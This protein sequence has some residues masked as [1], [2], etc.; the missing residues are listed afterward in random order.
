MSRPLWWATKS[1]PISIPIS[2][3]DSCA[4]TRFIRN[5]FRSFPDARR[6]GAQCRAAQFSKFLFPKSRRARH[7]HLVLSGDLLHHRQ[8]GARADRGV[9]LALSSVAGNPH[10]HSHVAFAKGKTAPAKKPSLFG[11]FS[12]PERNHPRDRERGFRP[13][14]RR[15]L[16]L[17]GLP[18]IFPFVLQRRGPRPGHDLFKRAA[19][20][21]LLL[22]AHF[23][24]RAKRDYL[25]DMELP[26]FLR[27][28]ID[29]AVSDQP[30]AAR[31][32]VLAALPKPP[33]V[34]PSQ[35]GRRRDD[36]CSR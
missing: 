8:L 21:L 29:P 18:A 28:Q 14:E 30:S 31:S 5:A 23:F 36:R 1:W 27:P 19:R 34:S 11:H 17:G 33:R 9:E 6:G 4:S 20:S 15:W 24:A 16:G 7:P 3:N 13:C 25:D 22:P 26:A 32:I 2:W 12:E 10:P 35:S